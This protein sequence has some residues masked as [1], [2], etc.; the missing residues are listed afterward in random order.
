MYNTD[1]INLPDRIVY[2]L[3]AAFCFLLYGKTLS[4]DL[5]WLDDYYL[6]IEAAP[7]LSDFKNLPALFFTDVFITN[8]QGFYRPLLNVSFMADIALKSLSGGWFF[9]HLLNIILHA[10]SVCLVY[11]F[12]MTFSVRKVFAALLALLF[13]AHPASSVAVGW[14]PG[15]NDLLLA[16]F[17]FSSF[18]ILDKYRKDGKI[19]NILHY[20]ILLSCAL[21]TK[22]SAVMLPFLGFLWLFIC[23]KTLNFPKNDEKSQKNA[24][25]SVFKADFNVFALFSIIPMLIWAFMRHMAY[26]GKTEISI[27]ETLHNFLYLPEIIGHAIFP[28]WPVIVSPY[29]NLPYFAIMLAF[30]AIFTIFFSYFISKKL[31]NGKKVENQDVESG[32]T[33]AFSVLFGITWFIMF[34]IPTFAAGEGIGSGSS[35]FEHRLYI[36]LTGFLLA[37]GI[38]ANEISERRKLFAFALSAVLILF[39]SAMSFCHLPYYCDRYSFW[40][41]VTLNMPDDYPTFVRAGQCEEQRGLDGIAAYYYRRALVLNPKQELLHA[42]LAGI[43]YRSGDYENAEKEMLAELDMNPDYEKGRKWLEMLRKQ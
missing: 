38:A 24:D 4:Y 11:K 23:K 20:S 13:A 36:P 31:R 35:F 9:T 7:F 10:A 41:Q 19:K 14:I 30:F 5:S 32:K 27:A 17:T 16:V 18:L 37:I 42:S 28:A 22:E 25:L 39:F 2:L 6:L 1:G 29:S 43:Y 33:V 40:R 3:L 12:L 15:R 34:F 26:I 8:P 21:F